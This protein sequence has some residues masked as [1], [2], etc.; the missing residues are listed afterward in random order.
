[1]NKKHIQTATI[2]SELEGGASL[3]FAKPKTHLP[4]VAT[5]KRESTRKS[6]SNST[7]VIDMSRKLSRDIPR[8][9]SRDLP[10]RDD[11][12]EFSFRL[13]DTLKVKIQA[14]VPY[15][16]QGQLEEISRHLKV[17]KLE[18]YRFIIGNFLG[19]VKPR[20]GEHS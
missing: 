4:I 3:F 2:T 8:E 16:W 12:Q 7:Q 20:K 19:E 17:K 10:T 13:R 1:M 18:L 9:D 15:E 5:V 11:I 14:E 6:T